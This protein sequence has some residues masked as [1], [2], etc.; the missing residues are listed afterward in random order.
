MDFLEVLWTIFVIYA[1]LFVLFTLFRIIVDV[2]R[3]HE[4]SGW[5]KAGWLLVLLVLPFVGILVYLIA[6][7][8][9][10]AAR[11]E[12]DQRAARAEFD[13]YVRQAAGSGGSAQEI[14]NAKSLLDSG[15]ISAQ[16][17]ETLKAKALAA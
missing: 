1:L 14:A 6:R 5:G 13:D 11:A 8:P 2:F 16:E 3:D 9:G 17:Y 10:M 15:A 12:Q 7:G 4:L